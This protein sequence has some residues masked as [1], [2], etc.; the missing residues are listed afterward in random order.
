MPSTEEANL[1]AQAGCGLRR[2][3]STADFDPFE[4]AGQVASVEAGGAPT[5][6][7]R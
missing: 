4:L 6:D 2:P 7:A 5:T 1:W 3:C